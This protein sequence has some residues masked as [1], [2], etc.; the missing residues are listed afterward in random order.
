MTKQEIKYKATLIRGMTYTIGA[1]QFVK[2]VPKIIDAALK[3]KLAARAVD[4]FTMTG[5]DGKEVAIKQ[6]FKFEEVKGDA[7]APKKASPAEKLKELE[8][9]QGDGGVEWEDDAPAETGGEAGA[10]D[11]ASE[12]EVSEGDGT[13]EVPAETPEDEKP[14]PKKGLF[15][16]KGG[17]N[18]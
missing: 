18:R 6:K 10:D 17:R 14:A 7:P 11:A 15:G 5:A 3:A 16:K 1:L 2:N 9:M 8:A 12:Y 4:R 13:D